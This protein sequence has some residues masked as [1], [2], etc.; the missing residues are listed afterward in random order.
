MAYKTFD[1]YNED[2]ITTNNGDIK[3]SA[4]SEN[5]QI[6]LPHENFIRDAD[7]SREGA[8]LILETEG[9]TIIIEGYFAVEPTPNLSAPN[10]TTLTPD[11]VNAFTR[12]GN[13][14]AN[15]GTQ[16]NDASPIG[17]VQEI[18]GGATVT[19]LDGTVEPIGIGTPIYQGDIVETDESGAVN[20]MFV[21]ET[22]FAVSEDA[23]L[24]IDEYVFDPST[25]SGTSN[26]S[27]LKGVFV[28]T[29]GLI[30]RDDPDDVLIDTPSGSIGIRGTIIAGDVNSGEITVIEGAIVLTDFAGNSVT[31]ANQ[32]ETA[33]FNPSKNSIE[34][35]GTLGAEDVSGKFMSI[36]TVAA[37]L[38][39]SIQDTAN[40]NRN[41]DNSEQNEAAGTEEKSEETSEDTGE[42]H[43][44]DAQ[45][46]DT[47]TQE[48]APAQED[49]SAQAT[50][51][52]I[53]SDDITGKAAPK[54]ENEI[55]ISAEKSTP[56]E[57]TTAE[58]T[59]T[60]QTAPAPKIVQQQETPFTISVQA[61]TTTEGSSGENVALITGNFTT[62]TNLSL[63]GPSNN[64]YDIVRIDENN[65]I[66]KLK[67]SLSIDAEA[68]YKLGIVA[69]NASGASA[70]RET[71]DLNILN[72]DEPTEFIGTT[73]NNPGAD[74]AFS[75]SENSTFSYNFGKDFLDPEGD[76]TGFQFTEGGFNPD[77][78]A[79]SLNFNAQTG[80][81]TFKLDGDITS[82]S[83]YTFTIEAQS[84]SGNI[85][86]TFTYDVLSANTN[87]A[88]I[89][90][91]G[92]IY[93]GTD[94]NI[95]VIANGATIFADSA[96][97]DNTI[98][99]S[100]GNNVTVKAGQGNDT[101]NI[102]TGS[103]SFIAYG[104][105]GN[106]T[107]NLNETNGKAYGGQGNDHF[108]LGNTGAL[109]TM[110]GG[111]GIILDGGH[112]DDVLHLSTGG[113]IDFTA[114]NDGFIKN[115]EK[116]GLINANANTITLSYTDVIAMTD[117]DNTLVINLD[118]ND[119][120]NFTN[121]NPSGYDFYQVGSN[122]N[123]HDVYTDGIV[124]LLI[125][126]DASSVTGII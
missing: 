30:G 80:E 90:T 46:E 83:T 43:S 107:F 84:T 97:Q 40:E 81:L 20:I 94:Q 57:N 1:D 115:I 124:T 70:I 105:Q 15:A 92:D 76:I 44:E 14:Y 86:K 13:E 102:A 10:G 56:T 68:P 61:L 53:T 6:N 69:T 65:L 87:T 12:G 108:I 5:N 49:P 95:T 59:Q 122:N 62:L 8:D 72:T 121:N 38:F 125:D 27:V 88:T 64:F 7:L 111:T 110:I 21:D 19:R 113:N 41:S 77:I 52:I 114:I 11:L 29:S 25:Q 106:D 98:D 123:G 85:S 99:I 36:S 32:Y 24:S 39:S 58:A 119:T 18:N 50:Q 34:S 93:A 9:G 42:T 78:I 4:T 45:S 120:L 3:L 116:I 33:R 54:A 22:S 104:D 117:E 100:S 51:E 16:A 73:P 79:S 2:F 91:P 112:G 35:M 31:L 101:I 75:G 55:K 109:T 67:Q 63:V 74:N 96:I 23:R 89:F 37:D 82:D 28:F 118:T 71:I 26:F 103:N 126:S 17:A 60:A 66:V 47:S 48:E